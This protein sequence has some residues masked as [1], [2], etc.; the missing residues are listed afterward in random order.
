M[1]FTWNLVGTLYQFGKKCCVK[2]HDYE[3]FHNK[4]SY[5]LH[6]AECPF[7]YYCKSSAPKSYK[8]KLQEDK[9]KIIKMKLE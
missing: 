3:K 7:I 8:T 4:V 1:N 5:L 6:K 2:N 9:E